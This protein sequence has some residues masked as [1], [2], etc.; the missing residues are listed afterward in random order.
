MQLIKQNPLLTAPSSP[1]NL[2]SLKLQAVPNHLLPSDPR[3]PTKALARLL[4]Q[5]PSAR[6]LKARR[7]RK[8]SRNLVEKHRLVQAS[9]VQPIV[10]AS[11]HLVMRV[12]ASQHQQ[13]M[14]AKA[15]QLSLRAVVISLT[16]GSSLQPALEASKPLAALHPRLL[17]LDRSLQLPP[18]LK[19]HQ[20]QGNV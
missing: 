3:L 15:G 2:Q 8:A 12:L 9:P 10:Q 17:P 19:T 16:R 7:T 4:L 14:V 1:Q 11:Q 20:R 5:A 18:I 6:L 13:L